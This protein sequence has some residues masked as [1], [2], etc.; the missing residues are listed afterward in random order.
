MNLLRR[1]HFTPER[2]RKPLTTILVKR[3]VVIPPIT[4]DGRAT[5]AAPKRLATP[6]MKR[7]AQHA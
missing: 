4:L 5:I 3:N 6:A 7:K 1:F 2:I